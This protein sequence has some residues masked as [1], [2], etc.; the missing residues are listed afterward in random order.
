MQYSFSLIKNT[1][2]L[3][4]PNKEIRIFNITALNMFSYREYPNIAELLKFTY[5]E[6]PN[7][8]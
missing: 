8:V 4:L 2:V 7:A 6:C 5:K 1:E 3:M